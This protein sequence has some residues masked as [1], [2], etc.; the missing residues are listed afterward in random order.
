LRNQRIAQGLSLRALARQVGLSA[1]A[2]LVDYEHG[3]RIPPED[4]VS[5]CE[6]VLGVDDALLRRLRYAALTER[7]DHR[8]AALLHRAGAIEL[9]P[10]AEFDFLP[11][12]AAGTPQPVADGSDPERAGCHLDAVTAH[13]R[14]VAMTEYRLIGQVE[15]RYSARCHAAWGRFVGV[16]ALDHIANQRQVDILIEAVREPDGAQTSFRHEYCFDDHWGDLLRTDGG[17]VHAR[18]TVYADDEPI[19]AG[20][21]DH[22]D[23]P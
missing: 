5:A 13:A 2:T 6:R 21:T 14:K 18:T 20:E 22:L 11:A 8:A 7:G 15:L 10:G 23:L 4:L 17:R 1:H 12:S 9:A 16:P 19:A 3:R